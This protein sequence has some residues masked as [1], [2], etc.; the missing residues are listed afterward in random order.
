[1]GEKSPFNF[2]NM[3]TINIEIPEGHE[4]DQE[5][6]N[7][8]EGKIVFKKIK[9]ELKKELPKTWEELNKIDGWYTN[10]NSRLTSTFEAYTEDRNKNNFVT[11]KQAEASLALAQLSQLREVYRQGWVPDW[12]DDNTGKWCI[13]SKKRDYV[14]NTSCT[15]SYFLS[16]QSKEIALEF[17]KNFYGLIEQAGPLLS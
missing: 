12:R 4:I 14:I 15:I 5:K 8:A 11:E 10:M 17:L 13:L 3:K 9:K 7:L 6:S 1:M 16:F 2:K